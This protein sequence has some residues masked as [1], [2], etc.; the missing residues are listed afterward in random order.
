MKSI[1]TILLLCLYSC[2]H[3][4]RNDQNEDIFDK[5]IKVQ[6]IGTKEALLN[7]F[8]S[9]VEKIPEEDKNLTEYKYED[10]STSVNE[11]N[12]KIIGTSMS[13]GVDYDAYTFLKKRFQSFSWIE[14]ELPAGK[15]LD[16][17]EEIHKVEIPEV[18]ISF[19]YDN[20]DPLR[21][22]MWIFFQI[23]QQALF[24]MHS[25]L[26]WCVACVLKI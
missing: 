19:E 21:R 1:F 20:Q 9:P 2:S 4:K 24:H 10:F 26:H 6:K 22:P 7:T 16:Y 23:E 5:I 8:G 12:G 11:L 13:F 14:T 15:N 25:A 3:N 18:G 17:A